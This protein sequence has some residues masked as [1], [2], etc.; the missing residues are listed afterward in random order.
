M[1]ESATEKALREAHTRAC[2][3]MFPLPPCDGRD[4][5]AACYKRHRAIDAAVR[6]A[7]LQ[8]GHDEARGNKQPSWL[9]KE[10]RRA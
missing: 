2:S 6:A 3:C 8:G 5:S 9:P 1:T 7:Y 10:A 4:K